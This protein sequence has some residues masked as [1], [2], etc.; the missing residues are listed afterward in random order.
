MQFDKRRTAN[1]Q[2]VVIENK[3]SVFNVHGAPQAFVVGLFPP[4]ARCP[5]AQLAQHS[6]ANDGHR[7]MLGS[8]ATLAIR[9]AAVMYAAYCLMVLKR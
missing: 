9:S 5:L 4:P 6:M 1:R 7:Q 3:C 8:P 2:G